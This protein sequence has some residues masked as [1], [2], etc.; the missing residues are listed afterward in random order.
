MKTLTKLFCVQWSKR[1]HW[2]ATSDA[3]SM[4]GKGNGEIEGKG[5]TQQSAT[6]DLYSKL[7]ARRDNL[8]DKLAEVENALCEIRANW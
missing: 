4:P 7:I 6:D 3:G 5:N 8:Q 2:F 1:G